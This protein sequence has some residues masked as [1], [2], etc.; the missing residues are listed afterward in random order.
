VMTT[1]VL[2]PKNGKRIERADL[3]ELPSARQ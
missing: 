1:K 3:R 2:V